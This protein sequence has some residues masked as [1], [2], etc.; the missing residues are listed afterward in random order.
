ME[1]IYSEKQHAYI[2]L[3]HARI[4]RNGKGIIAVGRT[5]AEAFRN[6]LKRFAF[7]F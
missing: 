3:Y 5:R 4:R 1:I 6:A 2:V 7:A